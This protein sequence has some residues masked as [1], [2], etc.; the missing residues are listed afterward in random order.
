MIDTLATLFTA[1]VTILALLVFFWT[2]LRVG[3]MRGKHDV[4]APATSG[5]PE[6]E[7]AFRVQMNTLEQIVIFLPLLWLANGYFHMLPLLVG[8]LGLVWIIGRIVY[9]QAY[10][11]DPSTRS[12]GFSI[13]GLATLGLLILSIVG[14]VQAW[15]ALG[16]N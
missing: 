3:A 12:L 8:A 9:A 14:I 11:A 16:A 6:F 2:G 5:H 15:M 1:L 13:S 7:R 10:M 4:K